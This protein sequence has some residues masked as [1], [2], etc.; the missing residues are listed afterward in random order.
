MSLDWIPK[1]V[2]GKARRTCFKF[3]CVGSQEQFFMPWV[4][5][6]SMVVPNMI[7]NDFI[8]KLV[9]EGVYTQIYPFEIGGGMD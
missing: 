1:G 7:E 3:L 9:D 4:K 8:R 6:E 2:L 5:W